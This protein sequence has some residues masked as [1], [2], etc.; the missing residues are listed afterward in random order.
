MSYAV[1]EMFYTLQGEGANMGTPAVFCR[2]AGCNLWSGREEDRAKAICK[3]CDTE[4]VGTNGLGGGKFDSA[5]ALA[6]AILSLWPQTDEDHRFVVFT[7]G[8]PALQLDSALVDAVHALKFRIAIE[9]NGTLNL[10]QGIDWICVS[11]KA[12]TPLQATTGDELKLVYPQSENSPA[13]Y[14]HLEFK[15]FFLSPMDGP[16]LARNTAKAI[17][18]CQENP[19]WRLNVQVHKVIGIA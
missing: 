3:F 16:D 15:H 10:P 5:G 1:K 2:F 4:F 9:T 8:E 13:M 19:R 6:A 17:K 11:P 14:E 7:G 12:E 18:Y